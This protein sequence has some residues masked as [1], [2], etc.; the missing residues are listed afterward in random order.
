MTT[1][2]S[3]GQI[4]IPS[5]RRTQ[6]RL[7]KGSKLMGVSTDDGF[8]QKMLAL[9]SVTEFHRCVA[10]RAVEVDLSRKDFDEFVHEAR[11]SSP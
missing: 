10:E 9:P 7:E 11:A 8:D 3:K 5:R 4:T 2:T 1:V 6:F